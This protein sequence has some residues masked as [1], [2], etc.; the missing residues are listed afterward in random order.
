MR[1]WGSELMLSGKRGCGVLFGIVV[2]ICTP[3]NVLGCEPLKT[4]GQVLFNG[5]TSSYNFCEVGR[6]YEY[7]LNPAFG[8]GGYPPLAFTH[9][10]GEMP[11]GLRLD[12]GT[13]VLSG[14]PTSVGNYDFYVRVADS[15]PQGSQSVSFKVSFS[16]CGKQLFLSS[17]PRLPDALG[18]TP[19]S[20]QFELKGGTPPFKYVLFGTDKLPPGL[21]LDQNLGLLSGTP[22]RYAGPLPGSPGPGY[23]DYEFGVWFRDS[24]TNT[25]QEIGQKFTLRV[26]QP[27]PV[28]GLSP[29][30]SSLKN[31]RPATNMVPAT[32]D[33]AVTDIT[34]QNGTCNIVVTNTNLGNIRINQV[35]R[36]QLWIGGKIVDDKPVALDLG[37]G[38]SVRNVIGK[39]VQKAAMVTVTMDP[40]NLLP[41]SKREN[42]SLTK[43]LTCP[44]Q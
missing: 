1:H 23:K 13:G 16:V 22:A 4:W 2:M 28:S 20:Y 30:P 29:V 5:C 17:P 41:D 38:V 9:A 24:C 33:L 21:T 31:L 11:P 7:S 43:P 37:P 36:Q 35:V 25:Q 6:W 18:G 39:P 14:T 44:V 19:F 26:N 27:R 10:G 34:L 42:N 3:L 32:T 12:S 40:D 15:C 8:G